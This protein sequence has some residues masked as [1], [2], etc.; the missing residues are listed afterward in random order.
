MLT[1]II[2]DNAANSWD[3]L[4]VLD[5]VG[6]LNGTT[7]NIQEWDATVNLDAFN[8]NY[9]DNVDRVYYYFDGEVLEYEF[10]VSG[11]QA[12]LLPGKVQFRGNGHT[13][14]LINPTHTLS[15]DFTEVWFDGVD[16]TSSLE[17][18]KVVIDPTLGKIEA[19]LSYLSDDITITQEFVG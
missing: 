5:M 1:S 14:T 10:I 13:V 17:E 18:L 4:N 8:T 16:V 2:I 19:Y 3:A 11:G 12:D 6:S 9:I 7:P 15:T